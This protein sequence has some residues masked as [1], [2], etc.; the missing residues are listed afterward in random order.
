VSTPNKDQ[1][2]ER[3]ARMAR[4]DD[5][6]CREHVRADFRCPDDEILLRYLVG[7]MA[8]DEAER[9]DELSVAD[10]EFGLRL[11]ALETDLVDAYVRS[12]LSG[13]TLDRFRSHYLTTPAR[14][15]KVR[16][17]DTLRTYQ[18]RAARAQP[19]ESHRRW[20]T[21]T[22]APRLAMAAV[23]ALALAAIGYL[24]VEHALL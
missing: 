7:P 8:H 1:I 11:K 12:E 10:E 21:M 3:G 15:E 2:A 16:L 19:P 13:E 22:A 20:L 9:F 5:R 6:A 4:R 24:L 17:A 23:A 18:Q 14:R